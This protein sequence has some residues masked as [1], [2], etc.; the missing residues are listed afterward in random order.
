M[1]V[2]LVGD[3]TPGAIVPFRI[4]GVRESSVVSGDG[5]GIC[6]VVVV[7]VV[8]VVVIVVGD[9]VFIGIVNHVRI[10]SVISIIGKC[11]IRCRVGGII[12]VGIVKFHIIIGLVLV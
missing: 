2:L 10:G 9:G 5:G 3:V 11:G 6:H 1:N 12:V 7:V 8:V 4:S